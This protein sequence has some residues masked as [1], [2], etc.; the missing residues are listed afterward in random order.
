[1]AVG[2]AAFPL[3]RIRFGPDDAGV[4]TGVPLLAGEPTEQLLGPAGVAVPHGPLRVVTAGDWM[5]GGATVPL[6]PGLEAAV[7]GLYLEVFRAVQGR[8][9]ARIW[10]YVPA[11]NAIDREGLENYGRFCRARARAFEQHHGHGFTAFLPAASAVG[12]EAAAFT[13]VFAAS[14]A[15][16][17]PV[18]NPLQLPAYEYPLDYGPRAPSFAR[19]TLVPGTAGAAAVFISGTAAIRGHATMAPERTAEQLECTL[20]NLRAI[21]T[22]CGLG[23]DLG[24]SEGRQRNFKVYLRHKNDQPAVAAALAERLLLPGDTVSYLRADI[25]RAPLNLEIEA[26]LWPPRNA[27]SSAQ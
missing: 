26:T 16:P 5:F 6:V 21:S 1:M 11:I 19:A 3:L 23:S 14:T 25:C 9:L 13:L 24:A 2:G 22:A 4:C 8:H 20:G 17:R 18:E 15:R 7:Y 12:C 27:G 10:N